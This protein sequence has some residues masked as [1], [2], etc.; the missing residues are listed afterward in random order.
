MYNGKRGRYEITDPAILDIFHEC[1]ETFRQLK[2]N[3][4]YYVKA[5]FTLRNTLGQCTLDLKAPYPMISVHTWL[6]TN[7][8]IL[9]GVIYH[10]LCH[11]AVGR[12][13]GHDYVWQSMAYV[14]GHA[15]GYNIQRLADAE[16]VAICH[17]EC[18]PQGKYLITCP[19]CGQTWIKFRTCAV[20]DHPQLFKHTACGQQ[21]LTVTILN[22]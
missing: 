14:I 20:V 6:L 7:P 22:K 3:L 1:N 10:E 15:T 5:S 16:T 4:P 8:K 12:G 17:Q 21:G 19:K 13:H 11:L 2:I 9:K 18:P